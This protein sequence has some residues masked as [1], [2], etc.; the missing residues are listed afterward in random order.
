MCCYYAPLLL[1]EFQGVQEFIFVCLSNMEQ[2]TDDLESAFPD[3][4][5]DEQ[6]ENLTE[7]SEDGNSARLAPLSLPSNLQ[8]LTLSY[9][10]EPAP[11]NHQEP[12]N[13]TLEFVPDF[14][15]NQ[16]NASFDFQ[17]IN[18]VTAN[19]FSLNAREDA[20]YNICILIVKQKGTTQRVKSVHSSVCPMPH[21][22]S[23]TGQNMIYVLR[24][25]ELD[26]SSP[27]VQGVWKPFFKTALLYDTSSSDVCAVEP[28]LCIDVTSQPNVH[29]SVMY[30]LVYL[31]FV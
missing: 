25:G 28:L 3:S 6:P 27:E 16:S 7:L 2:K 22:M 14:M 13:L 11:H 29:S 10:D 19:G 20:W 4:S 8:N 17:V 5:D 24:R 26:T 9:A 23:N 31:P 30:T 18:D 12:Q 15:N 1:A 21:T